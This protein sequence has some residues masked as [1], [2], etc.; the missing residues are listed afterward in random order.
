MG[1][2]LLFAQEDLRSD[3][4]VIVSP[5]ASMHQGTLL[6]FPFVRAATIAA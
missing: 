3:I 2:P 1:W 6:G 5:A 4:E